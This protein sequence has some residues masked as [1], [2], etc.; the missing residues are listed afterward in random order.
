MGNIRIFFLLT[1][2]LMASSVFALTF[3]QAVIELEKHN[4]VLSTLDSSKAMQAQAEVQ[5]SWGDPKFMIAAKNVPKNNFDFNVSPMT[6]IEFSLAKKIPL[7]H[8]YS[9]IYDSFNHKANSYQLQAQNIKRML[10]SQLWFLAIER[11]KLTDD[12]NISK[13][14]LDWI[15]KMLKISKKLYSNGKISQQ[16]L[17]EVQIRKSELEA[18]ISNTNYELQKLRLQLDYLLQKKNSELNLDSIPWNLLKHKDSLNSQLNTF[19]YQQR[20]LEEKLDSEQSNVTAHKLSYIPDINLAVGYTKRSD[21]DR[22]GDF[23]GASVTFELPFSSQKYANVEN[24]IQLKY[25]ALKNLKD[26]ELKKNE[27]LNMAHSDIEKIKSDLIIL[28][29]K[30]IHFAQNSRD[31]TAKSYGLG[32]TTYFELL[33]AELKLQKLLLKRS[34]LN[35]T[36]NKKYVEYKFVNG[37][38]LY[39]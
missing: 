39:E 27:T 30:T 21:L 10:I 5:S 22:N 17:L 7:T 34:S 15:S 2:I 19:D 3:N 16:A 12:L 26:Y 23:V 36:L 32:K 37:E 24:S 28:N 9:K 38:K 35:A 33:S 31:I 18:E 14:N 29:N 1:Q 25:A 6:G 13:E 20:I 8:K 4:T 11:K